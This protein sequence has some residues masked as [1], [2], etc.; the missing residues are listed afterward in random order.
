MSTCYVD[1][2]HAQLGQNDSQIQTRVYNAMSKNYIEES[3]KMSNF[4]TLLLLFLFFTWLCVLN[5]VEHV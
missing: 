1:T 2:K 5:I 4:S 3:Q